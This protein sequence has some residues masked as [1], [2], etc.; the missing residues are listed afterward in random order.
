MIKSNKIHLC[1]ILTRL[2][3]F[4]I[5]RSLLFMSAL[6]MYLAVP[7][8]AQPP[9]SSDPALTVEVRFA[10]DAL[11]NARGELMSSAIREDIARV[12][13]LITIDDSR[14]QEL[15]RR[16]AQRSGR[17][18]PAL[19]A[20]YRI[21]AKEG[22]DMDTF[23]AGLKAL[24]FVEIAEMAPVPAPPPYFSMETNMAPAVLN[25]QPTPLFE[26]LQGY[27][28][29]APDG[30]DARFAWTIPGG[31][32][33][34][35]TVYDVEYDW[36]QNHEDL[37]KAA[38]VTILLPPGHTLWSPF[39]SNNHGTAV[40][41]Q[42]IA[43][44]DGK[45]VTGISWGADVGMAAAATLDENN[46]EY[47][48]PGLAVAL[49]AADGKPGDVILIE[50][51]TCVCNLT[52]STVSDFGL[53][54]TEWISSAFDAIVNAT[55]AGLIVVQAAGNGWV[56]LDAEGCDGRFDPDD[57]A[58]YS[59]AIIVGAGSST[60]RARLDF[61]SYGRRVDLQGWGGNVMTTGYGTHYFRE[62]QPNNRDFW[63]RRSFSGTSS[64]SPIVAG[65]VLNLQGIHYAAFGTLLS[66]SEMLA[67]LR[68]T[69]TP[70]GGD[71]SLNIG[72]LPN[73]RAAIARLIN[74]PPVS[75][76]GSDQTL[77]CEC[78]DG[79]QVTLDGSGSSDEN[80]DPLT[81][82]WSIGA[83]VIAG[84]SGSPTTTVTLPLGVHV[85]TLTVSDP[86]GQSSTDDVTITIV[87]TT[88]PTLIVNSKPTMLWSPN[89][90]YRTIAIADLDIM[91]ADTCDPTVTAQ[92]VVIVS[93][94]SDEA[95]NGTGD[96]NTMNDMII[97]P[98]CNTVQLRA[99]RAGSGNGRVYTL[100]LEVMDASGNVGWTD[101]EVHVPVSQQPGSIA[102]ADAPVY[103][104]APESCQLTPASSGGSAGGSVS[105]NQLQSGLSGSLDAE[106]PSVYELGQNYPN[107]FNPATVITFALPEASPVR[108]SVYNMLGQEVAVLVNG[109]VEAGRHEARFDASRFPSGVYIY[110]ITAGSF[111]ATRM[112]VLVK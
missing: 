35:F 91:V 84:P 57:P 64:A 32:G 104:V 99:E 34:G 53:G 54:P 38:G 60:N 79:T 103:T 77:E 4:L 15:R 39:D 7:V 58:Q 14:L 11:P 40:L 24:P 20:W 97:G 87:D 10:E 42:L 106:R 92:D 43:D 17:A 109:Y 65:A 94:T 61:S 82:T 5:T 72:P 3:G 107:P 96:G 80:G 52:C 16:G 102:I 67:I 25:Y 101:Y 31:N 66:A 59:G 45:G 12:E 27:L 51:Q 44:K 100:R 69:G 23:K 68:D 36:N 22:T 75:D 49:A 29:P 85:I 47:Y 63:Y 71:T 108:L 28:D 62:D 1:P 37:S 48:N 90:D 88:P 30:I 46:V 83:E 95:E 26:D 81:Y 8:Q 41:G 2:P 86:D 21:V 50:Q 73:L 9:G 76:A 55:A 74:I 18:V 56:N 89:H 33:A 93:V 112:M 6:L 78:A 19:E 105:E 110:S 111:Q 13:R 98:D 70:Q